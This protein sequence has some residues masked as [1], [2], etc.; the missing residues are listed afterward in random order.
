MNAPELPWPPKRPPSEREIHASWR[1]LHCDT[2]KFLRRNVEKSEVRAF[3]KTLEPHLLEV[4]IMREQDH[5]AQAAHQCGG[6]QD[7]A[8]PNFS[9][10]EADD[11]WDSG[12]DPVDDDDD[13]EEEEPGGAATIDMDAPYGADTRFCI[14]M[15]YSS[16]T[17][18]TKYPH[19]FISDFSMRRLS[20]HPDMAAFLIERLMTS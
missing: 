4:S 11:E 8:R 19:G 16:R 15:E 3:L 5:A 7:D 6:D 13:S 20:V 18:D 2:L 14:S 1:V 10:V 9:E 12:I 17:V